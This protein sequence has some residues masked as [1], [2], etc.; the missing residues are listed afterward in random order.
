MA[1]DIIYSMLFTRIFENDLISKEQRMKDIERLS[2]VFNTKDNNKRL[3]DQQFNYV[4]NE[5][6]QKLLKSAW[7]I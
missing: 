2:A 1:L 3:L 7:D 6:K 4:S 5:K